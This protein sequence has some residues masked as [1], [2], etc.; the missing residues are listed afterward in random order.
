M[1]RTDRMNKLSATLLAALA[2]VLTPAAHAASTRQQT[3]QTPPSQGA[4]AQ[5]EFKPASEGCG[6][7]GKPLPDVLASVNGIKISAPDFSPEVRRR[8]GEL[9]QQVIEARR[10]ELD[11]QINS[12]LLDAEA[13]KRG[14]TAAKVVEAEIIAKAAEPTEAEAQAFYDA[15]RA[16]I[17]GEFRDAKANIVNYLREQR[18]RERA[19]AFSDAL[20]AGAQVKKLVPVATPPTT[21][22]DRARVLATVNGQ[23][24][25]SADIEDSLRPLIYNVQEQTF[26]MQSQDIER[27]VND[28]LLEQEAQKSKVTTRALLDREVEKVR[29]VTEA[30]A[31]KFYDENKARIEGDFA[32][33]K[34]QIMQYLRDSEKQKA[35]VALAQ[36]LR[37][38]AQVQTFLT[39]PEPPLYAISTDD[40]PTK[41]NPAAKITLVEFTD[42][43]CP[44]CAQAHPVIERIAQEY[45]DRV[46]VVV[47][48]YPLHQHEH[49]MKAAEA[50][51]AAR[52]QGKYWEYASLLFQNQTALQ[53]DKLKEYASRVG[54]DRGKFDA[55]LDNGQFTAKV[56]RDVLEGQSVGVGGTPTL[57]LNGRR[58]TDAS[59]DGLRTAIELALRA[60]A[61]QLKP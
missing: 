32:Q 37:G 26:R 19:S 43:Q 16:R 49:A 14:V 23:N 41:G 44:A 17:R 21:P 45:G 20:R 25:T 60:P 2:A 33:T 15:N 27:K 57:Y 53:V 31:Q 10:R 35:L 4:T 46:R 58:V 55:A 48:D 39:P 13:K 40:Q 7:E 29:P 6:C 51:E 52:A 61:K 36:R 54:L 22:A 34:E 5:N 59:Y 38:A 18:Q 9:R 50:A 47:R 56:Q 8:A 42:F 12:K 24:I 28:L 1:G 11:L 3:P 30:D